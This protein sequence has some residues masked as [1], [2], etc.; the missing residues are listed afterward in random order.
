MNCLFAQE[1]AKREAADKLDDTPIVVVCDCKE[2]TSEIVR[3]AAGIMQSIIMNAPQYTLSPVNIYRAAMEAAH[4]L[5]LGL[6]QFGNEEKTADI[7]DAV[8][9]DA[10]AMIERDKNLP[11]PH[12]YPP[13]KNPSGSA[14]V[15][16]FPSTKVPGPKGPN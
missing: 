4:A 1:V 8:A 12:I 3:S 5:K 7:D 9:K 10:A 2:C 16:P 15:L 6:I 14:Q 11:N 13:K